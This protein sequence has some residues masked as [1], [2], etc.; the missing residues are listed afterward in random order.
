MNNNP[1][2][3]KNFLARPYEKV[4]YVY[5]GAPQPWKKEVWGF[6][7]RG[8]GD[9]WYRLFRMI[10]LTNDKSDWAYTAFMF[11]LTEMV[12]GNR[13]PDEYNYNNEHISRNWL[14]FKWTSLLYKLGLRK[15][16]KYRSQKSM[17]RDPWIM[18]Y[19]CVVHFGD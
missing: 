18:M 5:L 11:A 17:T 4:D 16:R 14:E 2:S 7:P 9:L 19:C 6:D 13:W 3:D 12:D 1:H 8:I 15:T 10:I